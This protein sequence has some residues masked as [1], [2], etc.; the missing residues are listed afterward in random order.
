VVQGMRWFLQSLL[1]ALQQLTANQH[2]ETNRIIEAAGF[3]G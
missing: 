1:L 2:M 3:P